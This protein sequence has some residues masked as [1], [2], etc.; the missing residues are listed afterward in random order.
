MSMPLSK[1]VIAGLMSGCLL[2][3]ASMVEAE[4]FTEDSGAWLQTVAEGSLGFIDPS[5]KNG[6]IWL[7]GQSRFDGDWAH[8]YQGLVRSAL[9]YSVN[10]R[11]TVW[12]GY[13]WVPTQ[14]IGKAYVSQQDA[15]TGFRYV[16]PTDIGTFTFRTIWESNFIRGDQARQRPR[17]LIRFMHP[18]A[19]EPRLS[20]VAWDEVF[21]RIN[22]TEWGGESG[23]DQNR[24]FV[25]LG[26][27]FNKTIRGEVGYMN[28]YV[29]DA[30]HENH[31]M[32]HLAI[33]SVT[34]NF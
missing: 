17:Q 1:T 28:Q 6:R 14:N 3:S 5:L 11:A 26:W 9:G 27:R 19:F 30:R 15:W 25:G 20:L 24:A 18:L 12:L 8:W 7:E 32:R 13:N 2:L 33:A 21:Y 16:L 23:F 22:T 29:D 31:T 4:E 34:V 10:E